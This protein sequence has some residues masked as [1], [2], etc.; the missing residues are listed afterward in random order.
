[1][2]K[3]VASARFSSIVEVVS[4]LL[5]VMLELM[6]RSSLWW[7]YEHGVAWWRGTVYMH[8]RSTCKHIAS[9]PL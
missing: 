5:T 4:I 2:A 1:M 7:V 6:R 3:A 9:M 8:L